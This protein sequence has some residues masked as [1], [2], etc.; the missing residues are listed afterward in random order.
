[1]LIYTMVMGDTRQWIELWINGTALC[2]HQHWHNIC[3]SNY[4]D[5]DYL[6]SSDYRWPIALPDRGVLP[7]R[8]SV[9]NGK[10]VPSVGADAPL[11]V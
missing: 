2:E 9:D 4:S 1:M 11:P 7:D 6:R 3:I 8:L 5:P 10:K